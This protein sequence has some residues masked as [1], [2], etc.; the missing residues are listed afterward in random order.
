MIEQGAKRCVPLLLD[1][2]ER[3]LDL[4]YHFSTPRTSNI[5][6]EVYRGKNL[7][8]LGRPITNSTHWEDHRETPHPINITN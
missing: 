3:N 7:S 1:N 8:A 2:I 5:E 4:D 6:L